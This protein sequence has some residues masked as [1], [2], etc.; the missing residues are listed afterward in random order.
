MKRI[1]TALPGVCLIEPK[2]FGDSRGFFTETWRED[3][4]AGLGI[5]AQFVQDNWSRSRRGVLR[6][7]HYQLVQPQAKLVRV[8]TGAIFDV[9]VDIRRGSPTFGR[10]IGEILSEENKRAMYVPEG[11]AHGFLVLSEVCDC[12]YRCTDYYAP[13]HERG[14]LW[15]DPGIGVAWPLSGIELALSEKDKVYPRLEQQQISELP[16]WRE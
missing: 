10:W 3:R 14:V 12:V 8:I 2:V 1:D 16:I 4:F 15:S 11:F 6:G 5:S 7:L 13:A 9:V